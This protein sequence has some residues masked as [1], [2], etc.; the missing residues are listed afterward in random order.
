MKMT[1]IMVE[2]EKGKEEKTMEII[3]KIVT[4]LLNQIKKIN[5]KT[6]EN[7]QIIIKIMVEEGKKFL[8]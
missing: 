3:I 1:K 7:I 2:M 6:K 4:Y 5:Q 8:L